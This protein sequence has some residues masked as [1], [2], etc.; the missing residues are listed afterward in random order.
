MIRALWA[1]AWVRWRVLIHSIRGR[2][3]GDGL[4]RVGRIAELLSPLIYALL[5]IPLCLGLSAGA[6][7]GGWQ[8]ARS[9][10]SNATVIVSSR[11]L[12]ALVT[13]GVLLAPLVRSTQG[14]QMGVE[15]LLL[16][17]ISRRVLHLGEIIGAMTDPWVVLALPGLAALPAGLL[18]GGAPLAGLLVLL[19][20]LLFT[21]ALGVLGSVSTNG[22][23]LIFRD[24][25]R[26]EWVTLALIAAIVLLAF[27]PNYLEG[28]ET[29]FGDGD[30]TSSPAATEAQAKPDF[31]R[32]FGWAAGMPSEL[33][34]RSVDS[35]VT[36][37]SYSSLAEMAAL[38][39][40]ALL[41]FALSDSF[42]RRL[43]QSPEQ[44]S[45]QRS[46]KPTPGQHWALPGVAPAVS[47]I[48]LAQV[49]TALRTVRGK[50]AVYFVVVMMTLIAMI[51]GR[52][53]WSGLPEDQTA[54]I[55]PLILLLGVVLT[56]VSQQPILLNQFAVDGA[57]LTLQFLTPASNRD[58]VRGKILGC[59]ALATISLVLCTAGAVLVNP[60]GPLWSWLAML[61]VCFSA[62]ALLAPACSLTSAFLPKRSNLNRLGRAGDPHGFAGLIGLGLTALTLAPPVALYA[63]GILI[64]DSPAR[65]LL[66]VGIWCVVALGLAY[67]TSYLA[68]QAV[69]RRRENLFLIAGEGG[70]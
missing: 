66:L 61:L 50:V 38:C 17:P 3:R 31:E 46:G 6:L 8:M 41:L 58:L 42:H 1:L 23:M 68:E 34:S 62:F 63:V 60:G 4:E 20:G 10:D 69:A 32:Y 55:G 40:L 59:A 25:R 43:V 30:A 22:L 49:R 2:A 53:L 45:V 56:L 24:R 48:A 36:G 57:G 47:A 26:A 35:A 65:A 27:L 52:Q 9:G 64:L 28:F 44:S 18:L 11:V 39:A 21:A 12:L 14:L 29:S 37:H 70:P 13:A 19:A 7:I 33:Y 51:F 54:Q 67:P 16:L 5:L 15:R